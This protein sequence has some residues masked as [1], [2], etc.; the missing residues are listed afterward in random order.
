MSVPTNPRATEPAGTPVRRGLLVAGMHRS[1]TSALTR[2]LSLVGG[3]LA[4]ELAGGVAGDNDLGFWE[5]VEVV[6]LHDRALASAGSAWDDVSRFPPEWFA[7]EV[8]VA[9]AEELAELLRREFAAAPLFAIKDPRLCRLVPLWLGVLPRIGVRGQFVV[10]LR[11]PAEVAASL[12]ARN[13]FPLAKGYLVWLRNVLDA[14]QATRGQERVFVTYE[15]L[16]RDWRAV[17]DRIGAALDIHWPRLS[18]TA[19]AQVE[20][21]L[22]PELRRQRADW[23]EIRDRREVPAWA[24][25]AYEALLH[26]AEDDAGAEVELD[27]VREELDRA[28]D[29][30]GRALAG[31]GF[32]VNEAAARLTTAEAKLAEAASARDAYRG[33]AERLRGVLTEQQ[34]AQ[35]ELQEAV[36]QLHGQV[37]EL[38]GALDALNDEIL[39]V[40]ASRDAQQR[41]YEAR[42]AEI[43]GSTSWRFSAPVRG[44]GRVLQRLRG[45]GA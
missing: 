43:L 9:F 42:I 12:K 19:E 14:E 27:A 37:G 38:Q 16:L 44:V 31:M 25:R 17:V 10:P 45:D 28:D 4:G 6:A 7:S 36:G 39:R 23:T 18:R 20:D 33:E 3:A 1:G 22:S 41:E 11:N 26:L 32:R 30:Y 13:D 24:V 34:A 35:A 5:P 8:G 40:L 29:T 21:F 2:T 15:G